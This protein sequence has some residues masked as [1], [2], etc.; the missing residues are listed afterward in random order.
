MAL[1][2][3]KERGITLLTGDGALRKAALQEGVS[4]MGTLGFFDQLQQ[5]EKIDTQ[6][7]R[8]CLEQLKANNGKA[9]RLPANE[10]EKRLIA[11]FL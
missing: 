4:I 2:I 1:A 9:V 6:E 5:Q 8:F 7:M 10:T 11:L 3:A